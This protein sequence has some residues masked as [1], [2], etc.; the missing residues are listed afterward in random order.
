MSRWIE[1]K[2]APGDL[3]RVR[4]RAQAS[5]ATS[6]HHFFWEPW[7]PKGI[8]VRVENPGITGDEWNAGQ[9]EHLYGNAWPEVKAFFHAGSG[10]A[11]VV[12]G[13][14][15]KQRKMVHC[16][17]NSWGMTAEQELRFALKFAYGRLR[18]IVHCWIHDHLPFVRKPCRFGCH[19][20]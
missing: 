12:E 9:D 1:I 5:G 17:L 8:V 14:E 4:A 16:L 20:A 11:L 2:A 15:W 13:D 18:I 19:P 7:H 10:V 6:V 3:R